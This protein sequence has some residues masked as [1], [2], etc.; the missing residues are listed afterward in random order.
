MYG[1]AWVRSYGAEPNSVNGR[2]W[3]ITLAGLRKP[4]IDA[5]LEACR[6]EGS[7]WPP[8]APR[9]SAMCRGVPSIA[10]VRD[11]LSRPRSVKSAFTR[12]VWACIDPYRYRS[13]GDRVQERMLTEAYELTRERV[14]RGEPLPKVSAEIEH[15]QRKPGP[16]AT[17]EQQAR[18]MAEIANELGLSPVEVEAMGAD[19][20]VR[21][22]F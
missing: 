18:Y 5:G 11:E 14:M 2:E 21:S 9:F 4:D 19:G 1:H 3:G 8:S 22:R 13:N 12:A 20:L 6:A 16:P 10:K 7:E 15:Q 17:R